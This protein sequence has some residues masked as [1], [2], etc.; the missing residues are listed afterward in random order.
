MRGFV[1]RRRGP[2]VDALERGVAGVL[3]AK[4]QLGGAVK[5]GGNQE[6]TGTRHGPN[7]NHLRFASIRLDFQLADRP[8]RFSL[9]LD[10]NMKAALDHE[11]K[12]E[13]E[14]KAHSI[15]AEVGKS[16]GKRLRI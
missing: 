12:P 10:E 16:S 1:F 7:P 8:I 3:Y 13:L 9:F 2:H 14:A 6:I 5:N 15:K 11:A 4:K